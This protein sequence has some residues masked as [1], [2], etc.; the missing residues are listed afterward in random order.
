MLSWRGAGGAWESL[1][2]GDAFAAVRR[3]GQALIDRGLS[4][5][6]PVVILSG[7]DREHAL[8]SLAA[9]H[10]G[11][12]GGAGLA[13]VFDWRRATSRCSSTRCAL[14]TPGLVFAASG[15]AFDRGIDAAVPADRDGVEVI[16]SVDALLSRRATT[17][18]VD[19][20]HAA[21]APDTIA[22]ILLTSGSTAMPK[23]VINTHR[24]LGSNQEMIAHVLPFLREEPPVLVDWLP[25]HHTFGGNHNV[26]LVIHHGGTLYIDEGRPVP[27]QFAASVRN[28]REIADDRVSQRAARLRRARQS[29]ARQTTC[30]GRRS[31]AACACCSTRRRRSRST[32]RTSSTSSRSRP[33]AN[34]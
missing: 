28:L 13:G 27:G 24:M 7:N 12:H 6:R 14:L 25:W 2:Y 17:D 19:R 23:G 21:I 32:C 15:A 9:Q 10:V 31:S 16:R 8:L 4:A 34:G 30:C 33:A 22:K 20:A 11:H 18:A 26:G 29:D 3:I 5:E 1:T